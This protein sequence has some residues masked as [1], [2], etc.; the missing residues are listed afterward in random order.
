LIG[1]REKIVTKSDEAFALLLYEN[2]IDKW[3]T[4]GN[5][6]GN[7]DEQYEDCEEEDNKKEDDDDSVHSA[8]SQKMKT[9]S[10]AVRGKYTCHNNG[11]MKYE[12]WS[13]Q[14][15]TRFNELFDLVKKDRKCPRAAVMEKEFLERAIWN[16]S[17]SKRRR[18]K[19]NVAATVVGELVDVR[20]GVVQ[21]A[22]E[23]GDESTS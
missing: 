7:E 22:W 3:K 21:P 12:G 8:G 17:D 9:I 14:G 19:S 13:D 23:S 1:T 2:Y 11:T 20:G 6:E 18:T 15:M 10:K 16:S 4:Q 5:I